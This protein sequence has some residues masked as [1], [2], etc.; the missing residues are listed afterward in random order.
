MVPHLYWIATASHNDHCHTNFIEIQTDLTSVLE[1]MSSIPRPK[2]LRSGD[3]LSQR[4]G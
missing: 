4:K 3:R 2:S 1:P